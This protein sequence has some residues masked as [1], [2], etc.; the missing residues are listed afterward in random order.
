MPAEAES[1]GAAGPIDPTVGL[2]IP[3]LNP[4]RW[5]PRLTDALAALR[6]RPAEILVIDS[7]SDD[8]SIPQLAAAGARVHQIPRSE[9]DHGGTRNLAL[10]LL[11]TPVIVYLTQD[12]IPARPD[13]IDRLVAGL[14]AQA[15]TGMAFGRQLAVPGAKAATRAHR[16]LL[17]PD[18][19]STVEP[20]AEGPLDVRAGFASN[21]FCAYR[22]DALEAIGRFPEHIVCSEDRLSAGRMLRN[23]YSVRYVADA[24]VEHSHEYTV[25][26]TVRRYFDLGVFE[27]TNPWFRDNF[28][29][30]HGYGRQ[31][32]ARQVAAARSDGAAEVGRVITKSAAALA[33]YQLGAAY[34][35]L[36]RAAV[37]RLTMA[38]SYFG[39]ADE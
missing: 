5:L 21:S 10:D 30:P 1:S 6:P 22:R 18:V 8:G 34:R 23:G 19:S 39:T 24:V 35:R 3:T 17:Y 31:L 27:T 13:S 15:G 9:F 28:G 37:R 26:Q 38:P 11:D 16:A 7:S 20:D 2:C 4:G 36:P 32:V 33:G 29:R 14:T 25:M 12:A